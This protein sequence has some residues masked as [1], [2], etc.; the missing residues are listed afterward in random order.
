MRECFSVSVTPEGTLMTTRGPENRRLDSTPFRKKRSMVFVSSKSATVPC[1]SGRIAMILLGVRPT[2]RW[3][4][5]PMASTFLVERSMAT[6]AGLR[7]TSPL[8]CW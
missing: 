4:S 3:A 6:T 1:F 8:P 2:M 7:S 5:S